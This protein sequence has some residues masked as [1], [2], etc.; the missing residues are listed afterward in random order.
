MTTT[1]QTNQTPWTGQA[2][3]MPVAGSYLGL[4]EIPGVEHDPRIVEWLRLA[5][6]PGFGDETAWCAAMVG[7][8]LI[9]SG[10]TSTRKANAR[11][12]L[13]YGVKLAKPRFGCI[14]VF[15]RGANQ[16]QGH[17]AFYIDSIGTA[18]YMLGGNQGNK[19]GLK[20]YELDDLIEWRWPAST[21]FVDPVTKAA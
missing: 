11:S 15:E 19:V 12:Y 9:E 1:L 2:I 7:G 14:G 18:A 10:F 8:V 17:V 16:S 21:D 3:W 4:R 13:T 6:L 5:G 20:P